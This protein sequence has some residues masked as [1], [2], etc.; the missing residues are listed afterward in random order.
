MLIDSK[1]AHSSAR[2]DCEMQSFVVG[3]DYA[4]K[5]LAA[6]YAVQRFLN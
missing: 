5:S 1:Y 3:K 4:N 6:K 2:G